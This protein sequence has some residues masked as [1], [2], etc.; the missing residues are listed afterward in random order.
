VGAIAFNGNSLQT[1]NI[2]VQDINISDMP[3]KDISIFEIAHANRSKITNAGSTGRKINIVGTIS[4]DTISDFETLLDT[5]KGYFTGIEKNLDVEYAGATRRYVATLT[6]GRLPRAGGLMYS[7]FDLQFTCSSPFGVDIVSTSLASVTGA[8]TSPSTTAL[9]IGGNAD[10]QYPQIE[11]TLVNA[12]NTSGATVSISNNNNGQVCNITRNWVVGN[13]ITI[14]PA[15]QLVKI[16]GNEVEFTG[17]IP[18]FNK[19]LGNI[20]ISDTFDSRTY[21]YDVEQYRYWL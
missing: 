8:T 20:S 18:I 13:V 2:V 1:A 11:I 17:A 16:D 3:D 9:T 7:D 10:F 6:G 21:N 15:N 14:D 5:F 4:A 19:G 12:V